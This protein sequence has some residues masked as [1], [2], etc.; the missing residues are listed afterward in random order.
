MPFELGRTL[1]IKGIIERRDRR[2]SAARAKLGRALSIFEQPG[3][4]V[5]ADKAQGPGI[6]A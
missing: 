5:W 1:L 4:P 6:V 3:A 2:K